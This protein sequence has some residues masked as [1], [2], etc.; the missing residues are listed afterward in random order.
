MQLKVDLQKIKTLIENENPFRQRGFI[1][2]QT[3]HK[4][5]NL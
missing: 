4:N 3:I 2:I 1:V 5:K